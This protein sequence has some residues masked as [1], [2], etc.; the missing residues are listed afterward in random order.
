MKV[1]IKEPGQRPR[2]TE[3]ENSL[4]ELQQAVG[5]YIETVT[6]AED[7]CIICNEE[8]RLQGLPYNL[9][10]CGVSFVGT[11]LFVGIAGDEFADLSEQQVEILLKQ[12]EGK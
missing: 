1:I 6:L 5:G 12:M 9:T 7:C 8:G 4:S 2:V 10:F 11:I 3:I